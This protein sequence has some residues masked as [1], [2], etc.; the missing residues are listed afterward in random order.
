MT[1]FFVYFVISLKLGRFVLDFLLNERKPEENDK[2][3]D[4]KK[5]LFDF[6]ENHAQTMLKIKQR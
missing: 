5:F 4:K 1:L 2:M 3:S 6:I